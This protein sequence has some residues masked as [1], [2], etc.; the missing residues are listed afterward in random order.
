MCGTMS[1]RWPQSLTCLAIPDTNL[2][3]I[4]MNKQP[5]NRVIDIVSLTITLHNEARLVS[6]HSEMPNRR[7]QLQSWGSD[8]FFIATPL[9]YITGIREKRSWHLT[10]T[11]CRSKHAHQ[12]ST[13]MQARGAV[14]PKRSRTYPRLST[15]RLFLIFCDSQGNCRD[16]SPSNKEPPCGIRGKCGGGDGDSQKYLGPPTHKVT[17]PCYCVCP[18]SLPCNCKYLSARAVYI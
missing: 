17:R 4:R 13:K 15:K 10:N 7:S 8:S 9:S 11:M 6:A 12:D 18:S 3:H 1:C 5:T 2:V 16:A 14:A